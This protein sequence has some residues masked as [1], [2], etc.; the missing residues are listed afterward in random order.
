MCHYANC[1]ANNSREA[2]NPLKA[3]RD[4]YY[5]AHSSIFFNSLTLPDRFPTD[6][7]NELVA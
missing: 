2:V 3:Q 7:Y 5:N 6:I 4:V 1:Y